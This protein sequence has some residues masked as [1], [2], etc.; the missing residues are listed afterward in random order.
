MIT[1]KQLFKTYNFSTWKKNKYQ[2]FL[3]ILSIAISAAILLSIELMLSLNNTYINSNAIN[4]NEGDININLLDQSL[5]KY[6][7]KE[8]K[9]F[10]D[11]GYFNYTT[12]YK[13]QNNF[14][15]NNVSST[16]FLKF[17][18]PNNY[19]IINS[20]YN[21]GTS[22]KDNCV[23]INKQIAN[24]FNLKKGDVVS[25]KIKNFP[26]DIKLK[27]SGII[28]TNVSDESIVG[29]IIINKQVLNDKVI[30]NKSG[31]TSA[32][33]ILIKINEKYKLEEIEK[34][35][36]KVFKSNCEINT[37]KD[38]IEHNKQ[39]LDN[40][41]KVLNIIEIIVI[42]ISGVSIAAT[43]ILLNLKR[44]K[45]YIILNIYGM[46]E[47]LLKK[48]ILYETWII[49]I[50]GNILGIVLSFIVIGVT[51]K[52]IMGKMNLISII[53]AS[54]L[55]IITTILFIIVETFIFT[56]FAIEIGNKV[57]PAHILRQQ[58]HSI[59]FKNKLA[60]P[61]FKTFVLLMISFGL[62]IK[63]L[64]MS[65]MY[66]FSFG[67]FVALIFGINYVLINVSTKIKANKNKYI[68]LSI[69]NLK[70]QKLKFSMEATSLT[71]VVF[72]CGVM[73]NLCYGVIPN[74]MN[75]YM[76]NNN[77]YNTIIR[78]TYKDENKTKTVLNQNKFQYI[79]RASST[80]K[81]ISI[82]G[83]NF[84]NFLKDNNIN[85]SMRGDYLNTFSNLTAYGVDLNSNE[86]NYSIIEG[87]GL[88][89]SDKNS[90]CVVLGN[91]FSGM[92]I[93]VNDKI[94]FQIN[95]KAL[96]LKVVGI[97]KKNIITGGDNL[98]M[99]LNAMQK[100]GLLNDTDS[101]LQYLVKS[102]SKNEKNLIFY[103]SKELK[104][105]QVFSITEELDQLKEYLQKLVLT[106]VVICFISIFS[107]ICLMSNILIVINYERIKEFLVL[108]VVGA[109]NRDIR[110]IVIIE[111]F[112]VGIIS[113]ILAELMEEIVSYFLMSNVLYSQYKC[114][115][116]IIFS[117]ICMAL[118]MAISSALFVIANMKIENHS[119]MFRI[120]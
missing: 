38:I 72:L 41:S 14:I 115:I 1:T 45:D 108:K 88:S 44:K 76:I 56:L 67:I 94:N 17:V 96:K 36:N 93:N 6:Q 99:S 40:E 21:Y 25:I 63:S 13:F 15:Y 50:V 61:F 97:M 37:Y 86:M 81:L 92:G 66:I 107:A 46:N 83:K 59:E 78:T 24:K 98:Y 119:D 52:S 23:V 74:I 101:V 65:C 3:S 51:Q 105:A 28:D 18:D 69:R 48:L 64:P 75:Q 33:N 110:K 118:I 91:E 7:L 102:S 49:S 84:E 95:G 12:I 103:L 9:D 106:V 55:Q 4:S 77:G 113:G 8:L 71:I 57:N 120:D 82:N 35:I 20:S 62:Y 90:N 22:L 27:I 60:L 30:S 70:R 114:N 43:V 112:V 87:R 68:L 100:N 10:R 116:N 104:H 79:K 26:N 39:T 54:W 29:V 117:M 47:E 73:L 34:K 85:A 31:N 109:K 42:V 80:A 53:S 89:K 11:K 111:G 5:T 19:P 2:M 58:K 16:V 32:S